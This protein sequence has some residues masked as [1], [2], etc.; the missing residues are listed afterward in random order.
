MKTRYQSVALPLSTVWPGW[1]WTHGNPFVFASRMLRLQVC[2]STLATDI[3]RKKNTIY[4]LPL[5]SWTDYKMYWP[6]H[7]AGEGPT[8][9]N[10]QYPHKVRRGHLS[11]MIPSTVFISCT[12]F[13]LKTVCGS[14]RDFLWSGLSGNYYKTENT[15]PKANTCLFR[16]NYWLYRNARAHE[17]TE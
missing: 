3:F 6:H 7:F 17:A 11:E 1:P 8:F 4:I 15:R 10:I 13:H 12:A 16:L 14:V 2:V 5:F 9:G